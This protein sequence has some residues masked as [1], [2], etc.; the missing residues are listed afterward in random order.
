MACG[1]PVIA[2]DCPS[3]PH[4]ILDGGKIAP[5]VPVDDAD[6]L[7][8]ALLASLSS[9]PDTARAQVQAQMSRAQLF[10]VSAAADQ[11]LA[12]LEQR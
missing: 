1:A 9:P 8:Q 5:L 12:A 6:A 7:G 2:T 3:G 11:Y 4:E 10:S